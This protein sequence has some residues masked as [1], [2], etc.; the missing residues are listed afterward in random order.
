MGRG[1]LNRA[2]ED[3]LKELEAGEPTKDCST[4]CSN[5][6]KKELTEGVVIPNTSDFHHDDIAIGNEETKESEEVQ[7]PTGLLEV[8]KRAEAMERQMEAER[9]HLEVVNQPGCSRAGD[10]AKAFGISANS[11][12]LNVIPE[13]LEPFE[14]CYSTSLTNGLAIDLLEV[15]M[16]RGIPMEKLVAFLQQLVFGVKERDFQ[17]KEGV[18]QEAGGMMAQEADI[19]KEEVAAV[20]A[21]LSRVKVQAARFRARY[22]QLPHYLDGY[23]T[24]YFNPF[25]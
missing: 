4:A 11:I 23:L 14:G 15:T 6:L 17:A 20:V 10:F 22:S 24:K 7:N 3:I 19:C 2:K 18:V 1:E 8:V 25:I 21:K 16:A 9:L 13:L 5:D 12:Q